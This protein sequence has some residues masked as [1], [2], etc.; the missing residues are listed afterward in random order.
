MYEVPWSQFPI[1]P[2]YPHCQHHLDRTKGITL[3]QDPSKGVMH[4]LSLSNTG[5]IPAWTTLS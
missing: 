2:F 3:K 4:S 1:V 5:A